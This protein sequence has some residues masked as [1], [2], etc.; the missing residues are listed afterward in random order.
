MKI[1]IH[2]PYFLPWMGYFSKLVYA[3]KFVVLDDVYF[4][5]RHYIDRTQYINTNGKVAWLGLKTGENFGAKIADIKIKD[6]TIAQNIT[7]TIRHSYRKARFF[8]EVWPFINTCISKNIARNM[9]LVDL[10][11]NI[12]YDILFYLNITVPDVIKTSSLNLPTDPTDRILAI[13]NHFNADGLIIGN[14]KTALAHNL[15]YLKQE[16]VQIFNQDFNDNHPHYR[17]IRTNQFI[18]GLSIIDILFNEGKTFTNKILTDEKF[19]PLKFF[20]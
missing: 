6:D 20:E 13:Y 10:D 9:S 7:E 2:H 15:H 11:I 16:G 4:S 19:K 14:G 8:D 1:V 5:K 12:V 18:K 3:D 17:Q